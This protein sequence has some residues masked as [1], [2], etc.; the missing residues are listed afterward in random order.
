MRYFISSPNEWPDLCYYKPGHLLGV[1]SSTYVAKNG[2]F[3]TFILNIL[4]TINFEFLKFDLRRQYF[5]AN[6]NHRLTWVYFF[7]K[8]TFVTHYMQ[9]LFF[10]KIIS[11]T[12][13]VAIIIPVSHK[14]F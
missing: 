14:I 8:G 9:L 10:L 2:T 1:K 12:F 3:E 11:N 7:F 4:S 5:I 6:N 13:Y